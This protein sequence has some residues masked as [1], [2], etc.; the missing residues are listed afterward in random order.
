MP[1]ST[2]DLPGTSS[3]GAFSRQ[4]NLPTVTNQ[5]VYQAQSITGRPVSH[6]QVRFSAGPVKLSVGLL[7][8][9][10]IH[11]LVLEG[12]TADIVL[13]LPWFIQHDSQFAWC[14]GEVLKWGNQ[15][16]PTCFPIRPQAPPC[17]TQPLAVNSTSIESPREKQSVDIPVC[18]VPFSD[19]F[20]P[21]KASQLPTHRP[22]DGAIDLL[23]G[24]PVPKGKIY[25]LSLPEQKAI[26]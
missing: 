23:Q 15:C 7:N 17:Q 5:T 21:K 13:G 1:F 26:E 8:K 10:V 22:W 6:S 19:V 24:E 9:E 4:L 2:R 12:A 3:Q 20:C 16:F 11:L 14:T 18:Y 25:P